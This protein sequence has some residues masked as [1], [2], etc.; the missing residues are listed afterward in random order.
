[1]KKYSISL[2]T[3]CLLASITTFADPMLATGLL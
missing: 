1:M 3:A 2:V